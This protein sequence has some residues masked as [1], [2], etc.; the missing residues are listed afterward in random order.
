[1][2]GPINLASLQTDFINWLIYGGPG[3]GKT[4]L[5]C[6]SQKFRTFVFDV[7]DGTFSA[8]TWPYVRND[9]V[10]V[11][12]VKSF[13]DF[14]AGL[15][16]I[17]NNISKYQL[18]VTDT[19]TELQKQLLDE[20]RKRKNHKIADQQDWGEL[21]LALDTVFRS[22]RHL[23]IHRIFIAHERDFQDPDTGRR[24][25]QPS[26]QGSFS[27]D[28]TKHFD[29]ITR[30]FLFERQELVPGTEQVGMVTYRLLNCHAD[31]ITQAKD[32]SNSL[33]KY[34]NPD[35]DA[36]FAKML[37]GLQPPQ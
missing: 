14:M 10:D 13:D 5:G 1:V 18:V 31:Q 16:W 9:L 2:T 36:L 12:P 25:F 11:W 29:V 4:I 32:R 17:I 30:Y 15:A 7:D 19:C 22:F 26:F 20:I 27:R 3:V 37:A 8:R 35:L 21:L 34:E 6:G 33:A 23:P 24:M 28:Y